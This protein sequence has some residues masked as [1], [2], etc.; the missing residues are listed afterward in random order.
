MRVFVFLVYC[1][2]NLIFS[3]AYSI[4]PQE[5]I[6]A[7]QSCQ[8]KSELDEKCVSIGHQAIELRDMIEALQINPQSFGVQIMR[9]QNQLAS[10]LTKADER[11]ILQKELDLR[12]AI[13]G[14]LESPK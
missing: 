6:E 8:L 11:Q 9:L 10:K 4:E 14:W 1:F 2:F 5:I 13:V 12:L 7:W 3:N